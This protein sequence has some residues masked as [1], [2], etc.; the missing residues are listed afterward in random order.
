MKKSGPIIVIEDDTEDQEL[1]SE[2]FK[3][4]N[5]PNKIMFFSNGFEALEYLE[6]NNTIPFM[7]LSDI[8]MP[9]INGFDLRKK[10]HSSKQLNVKCIPYLFFTT[11]VQ[12]QA[13]IDAFSLSAQG[14]FIKPNSMQEL[15]NTIRK[16]VEYWQEC[17]LPSQYLQ[18]E[19]AA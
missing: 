2:I 15:Q 14:F 17:C 1:L 6:N 8:N 5:Y 10:I 3:V 13:V 18:Q 19:I 11:G 16:I 9:M 7:I 12:R 4:L